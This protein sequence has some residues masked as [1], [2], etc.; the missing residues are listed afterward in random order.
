[1]KTSHPG[2]DFPPGSDWRD[3]LEPIDFET[4]KLPEVDVSDLLP[5]PEED[6]SETGECWP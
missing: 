2:V 5:P 1:M 3:F 4:K 6:H